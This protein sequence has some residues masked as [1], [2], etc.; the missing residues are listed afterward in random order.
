MVEGR[1]PRN[2]FSL[3]GAVYKKVFPAV[4]SEI[5]FWERRALE[6]PNSELRK[7]AMDSIHTKRFHCLGGSVYGLLSKDGWQDAVRFIVSYQTMCDYLDNLCD[8][9][10]STDPEDF[11]LLHQSLFDA[12]TPGN[13]IKNYYA[14]RNEQDDG[15]YLSELVQAC[16]H[17]ISKKTS[18]H[19][20][21]ILRHLAML[22]TDLQVHKHVVE[23]ERINRLQCWNEQE[24]VFKNDLSWYEFAAASGSTLGIF[25]IVSYAI[26]GS[27][28]QNKAYAIY[29]SYFPYVQG[30]HIMMDYYID[31][32]EDEREAELNF[33]TF[34]NNVAHMKRRFIHFMERASENIASLPDISFHQSVCQGLVGLYLAD[35]KVKKV[36]ENKNIVKELLKANHPTRTKFFHWNAK[37]YYRLKKQDIR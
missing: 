5:T 22:Y 1:I 27:M 18:E 10:T 8:R 15:A 32:E 34:Y 33:C 13:S 36:S 17:I 11:R 35:P 3:M 9:S 16:Q 21:E 26:G 29:D 14:L 20:R 31:R 6:I 24:N 4:D 23:Q 25:C 2:F 19:T 30:L 12:L 28:S 7:Q 37:I